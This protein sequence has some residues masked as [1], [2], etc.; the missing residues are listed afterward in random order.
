MSGEHDHLVWGEGCAFPSSFLHPSPYSSGLG[1]T[2]S[3]REEFEAKILG[4]V[5]F[6][7]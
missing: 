3:S 4:L 2:W 5:N 6:V 1:V 7:S